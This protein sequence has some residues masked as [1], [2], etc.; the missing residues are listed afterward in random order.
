[1]V[2]GHTDLKVGT[3]IELEGVPYRVTDYSHKAMGRG[4]AVVQVKIKNLLTGNVLE[5]SFRSSDKISSAEVTRANMQLLYREG[6]DLVFMNN[7]TYDQD[8]V[9]QDVLGDQAKYVADSAIV[10]LLS[11]NDRVIG[12]EMPNAVFLEV[13]QTEPGAKGDTATTALKPATLE[14]GVSVM[15]PLFINEGDKIKVN[16]LTGAYLERAK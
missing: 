16:T 3:L 2:Y 15:V 7:D 8:T 11:F 14:T 9:G 5:R 1:M 4:G 6:S 13:I 10:Q 12:L